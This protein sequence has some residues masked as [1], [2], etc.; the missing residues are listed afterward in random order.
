M[1]LS[2]EQWIRQEK[3]TEYLRNGGE[4]IGK[5]TADRT[6]GEGIGNVWKRKH[7]YVVL[8]GNASGIHLEGMRFKSHSA[9]W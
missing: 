1:G 7:L 4:E 6:G 8:G 9:H 5:D 3:I 2:C